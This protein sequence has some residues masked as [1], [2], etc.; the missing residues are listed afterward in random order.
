[1]TQ[2]LLGRKENGRNLAIA[3]SDFL[4]KHLVIQGAT[5]QRKTLFLLSV[6]TQLISLYGHSVF[7]ID[8]GGEVDPNCWTGL[9]PE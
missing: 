1:M 2:I 4:E 6:L 3:L 9:R 7:F 5:G 8:L